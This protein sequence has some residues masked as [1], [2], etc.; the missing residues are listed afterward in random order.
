MIRLFLILFSILFKKEEYPYVN[1]YGVRYKIVGNGF[2]VLDTK[3][4]VQSDRFREQL[5]AF[6]RI[7][8]N[9]PLNID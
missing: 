8:L 2:L 4:L 9:V 7:P 5:E 1:K 3:S 6:R